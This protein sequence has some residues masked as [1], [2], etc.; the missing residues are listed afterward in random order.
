M[1]KEIKLNIDPIIKANCEV[2]SIDEVKKLKEQ[3]E[4]IKE[5]EKT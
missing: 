2:L 4:R 3:L 5:K 1:D